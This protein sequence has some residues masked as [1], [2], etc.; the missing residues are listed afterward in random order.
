MQNFVNT[1]KPQQDL[2]LMCKDIPVY[3]ADTEAV[4]TEGLLPGYMG[5]FPCEATF[6]A[7]MK[8]RYSALSNSL[9]RKLRGIVFGQ[10]NRLRINIET[11]AFSL[12]DCYWLKYADSGKRFGQV[13]PYFKEFWMGLGE[14]GGGAIPSLYVGGALDK[15]WNCNRDLVKTGKGVENEVLA[16]RL[17]EACGIKCSPVAIVPEGICIKNFTDPDH[18]LEQ[19]DASGKLDPEDF[20]DVDIV[21]LFG[22][23]GMEMLVIDA[24]TAN[25]DRHA[26]NF[27]FLR[28][29]NTGEYLDMAPLYDFD[30]VLS[31]NNLN[32][33]LIRDMLQALEQFPV[34]RQRVLDIART[35]A[36]LELHPT[37]TERAKVIIHALHVW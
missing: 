37:F 35:A 5:K 24:I 20:T 33:I 19:A 25:T 22:A 12:S 17:C 28:D 14:Y 9:A 32:D 1:H 15:Y 27:G 7:W 23:K 18:M 26:G 29:A 30:Q 16:V 31:S 3:N 21:E 2:I 6:K 10:G 8:L 13:S 34:Y 36:A 4:I 11:G